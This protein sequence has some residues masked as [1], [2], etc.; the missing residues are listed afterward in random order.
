MLLLS[1][2]V[3]V[4]LTFLSSVVYACNNPH[5]GVLV[6]AA[7][8]FLSVSSDQGV[9]W[10]P[11]D[12]KGQMTFNQAACQYEK[13]VQGLPLNKDFDWKVA[14]NGKWG[15]DKGC[16][17]GAN[18]R[19]NSGSS[20][21]VLLIY[22]P[23]TSQLTTSALTSNQTTTAGPST[24]TAAPTCSNPY[25]G[26]IVRAA[27]DFQTELGSSAPW[28]AT[29]A[30]SLMTLDPVSCLYLLPLGGLTP[31]KAYEWK[32]TF[33]NSW[34]N[35]IGCNNGGNCKFTT[36]ATGS[37]ELVFN[38]NT[39]Q[40]SS[41][42]L[43]TVCGNGECELGET[44]R[45]CLTDCGECPPAVCGDG[46]CEDAESCETC[47]SDCGKCPVCGDGTCQS[48]ESHQTCPQDCPNELP[49]CGIF[50]E[51]SCESGSQSHANAGVDAKRWQTP[52]PGT[53]GYQPSYQDYNVLVGYADIIY[54]GTDRRAADVCI[55]TKH[56][57]GSTVTLTY[58]FDGNAQSNKCK[59]FTAAYGSILQVVV[60]GSDGSTLELPDI[61]LIWNA[62]PIA[63]RQG[64]Y[65]N[66]Q[67]GGVAEM[68]GWP[69]KDVEQEC[70]FLAKAG[71]LG[72]KL[73]PVHEQ[74]MS[75]QPFEDAMNPWYF[76]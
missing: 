55:E 10:S 47:S 5:E 27:G 16:N 3:V 56:R 18:C 52:K 26:R 69:H 71:Y 17:G 4:A 62:K 70:E 21:V 35:S 32:V 34:S 24:S 12:L 23:S 13:L 30:N 11:S 41:R 64:D 20:G 1:P 57:Y 39:K 9:D 2:L 36:S 68:F 73:F 25:Q 40:L 48:N 74:L 43:S 67:K 8:S 53:N 58:F 76:M 59:R 65:R 29:E 51:E 6:V 60:S 38:P 22:N 66:G 14:F 45:T 72:V 50:R 7:G 33:D 44:C 46:K 37:I 54:T 49:G 75:T 63:S 31:N 15:G 61:D 42:P 19:F 28:L